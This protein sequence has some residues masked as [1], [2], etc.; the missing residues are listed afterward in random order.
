MIAPRSLQWRISLWLGLGVGLMWI[1]AAVVTAEELRHEMDRVFDSALQEAA[2]RI[3]PLAVLDILGRGKGDRPQRMAALRPHDEYLT[4]VVRD[5]HGAVLLR[6]RSADDAVFPPF[7]RTGFVDTPTHRIYF[8]AALKGTMTI[9]VA[10]PLEHRR[11][12]ARAALSGLAWPLGLLVPLSLLA[13]FGVVRASIGPIRGLRRGIEARGSGDLSPIPAAGLPSEIG[14]LAEAVNHLLDKLRRALEAERSFTANAAHELR[15]PV[16]AALAQVQ[17]LTAETKDAATRKRALH[18]EEALRRLA[19]LSEKLMQLAK[20]EGGR[21]RGGETTDIAGI[22]RIVVDDIIRST[23][24]AERVVLDLPGTAVPAG[25]DADAFAIVV[26]NLVENGL[27]HGAPDVAVAVTLSPDGV[28]TVSN[29][30]APVPAD[31]L[32]RLSRP[33]ER[34]RTGV[35]GEGLGLA[36]AHAVASGVGGNLAL[37]SPLPGR[38]SGFA[39]RFSMRKEPASGSS[40]VPSIA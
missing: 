6:S 38:H 12:V 30:G 32:A 39:A 9:A 11:K 29:E 18:V 26:R 10:E 22:T 15:T 31:L 1:V 40:Q 5:A 20:A 16:A 19:R 2:E 34:G 7:S 37:T 23:G 3:L 8:D 4:Y 13:V 24:M 14:P 27:K 17:R 28:L 25:I 36:I 33:F 21:L 35:E